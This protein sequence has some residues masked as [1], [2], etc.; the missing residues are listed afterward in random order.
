[1]LIVVALALRRVTDVPDCELVKNFAISGREKTKVRRPA[2][3]SAFLGLFS[4]LARR[5]RSASRRPDYDDAVPELPEVESVRRMLE[6]ALVGVRIDAVEVRRANLRIP[7][8]PGFG[9]RLTGRTVTAVT[10]RA[11]YLL[12]ALS[13]GETLLVHL[14]MSGDFRVESGTASDQGKHDHVVFVLASGQT[15]TFND[16]RRFGLMDLIA[17]GAVDAHPALEPLGPEPL[18]ADFDARALARACHRKQVAIKVALLDQKVVAGVGNIYASEAL[19]AAGLSP[20]RKAAVLA[21][22]SGAPTP[23]AQRLA[24]AIVKVLTRAIDRPSARFKVYE[25]AG[26]TCPRRGCGGT[27]R[28]TVQAGRSTYFCPLCQH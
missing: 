25:R 15:V 14:G 20:K 9:D 2:L 16:P 5:A 17:H 7:F 19:H 23:A 3:A 28:R 4:I 22:R 26:E 6:P 8:P 11:K 1:V 18:S 13:S 27:I 12:A 24:A 10:R 21:T